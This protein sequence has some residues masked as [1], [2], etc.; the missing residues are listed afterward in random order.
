ML[1]EPLWFDFRRN[2]IDIVDLP[3]AV[4]PAPGMPLDDDE[5]LATYLHDRGYRYVAFVRAAASK[6]LYRRTHWTRLLTAPEEIWRKS[7]PFYLKMFD[8]WDGLAASRAHLY[9]D[10]QMVAL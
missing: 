1:D 5:K 2:P 4:S 7:A 8:R 10:G 9:D 3:G 6:S